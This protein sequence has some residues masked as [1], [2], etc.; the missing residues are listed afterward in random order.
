[1]V[2]KTLLCALQY[3]GGSVIAYLMCGI[4]GPVELR[5]LPNG[6]PGVKLAVFRVV[7]TSTYLR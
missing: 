7:Y 1:M 3:G 2:T 4:R 6:S 5:F